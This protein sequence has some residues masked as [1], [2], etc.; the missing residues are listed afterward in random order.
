MESDLEQKV[1]LVT[2]ASGGLGQAIALSLAR[3]GCRM[4]VGFHRSA[5]K[6]EQTAHEVRCL[7]AEAETVQADVAEEAD[8]LRLVEAALKRWGRLDYLVNCAGTTV[9]VKPKELQLL[10][11]DTW[12]RIMAVNV[13]GAFLATRAA[14]EALRES[15]GAVVNI[16]STAAQTG[17]GSSIPYC[18]SK[19]ALNSLTV[20]LA[21]ALA[22]EIRVNAVAPG[23]VDTDWVAR[24]LGPKRERVR[25]WVRSRTPLET[26]V[27]PEEVAETTTALLTGMPSVTGQILVLDGGYHHLG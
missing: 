25:E 15:R 18:A 22:P 24:G 17:L 21:R 27:T 8:C 11:G 23:F 26:L 10:D 12:D 19:A 3:R 14:A 20:T 2:G 9:F 7:G 1:A 13:K 5:E 4:V 16:S 6:A